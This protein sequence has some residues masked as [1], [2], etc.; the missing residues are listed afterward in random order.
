MNELLYAHCFA[1]LAL[2]GYGSSLLLSRL[3]SID[4]YFSNDFS[5][6]LY[7]FGL[8]PEH[9]VFWNLTSE[10]LVRKSVYFYFFPSATKLCKILLKT[11]SLC[12]FSFC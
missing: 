1:L 2:T 4:S 9:I 11:K 6:L 5:F 12:L 7:N 10:S 3:G 8:L